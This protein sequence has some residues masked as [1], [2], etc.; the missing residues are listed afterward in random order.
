[1]E[2]ANRRRSYA[3]ASEFFFFFIVLVIRSRDALDRIPADPGYDYIYSSAKNGIES[4]SQGDPYFHLAARLISLLAAQ[5]P[6][7]LQALT[8][9]LMTHV[10]WA[11]CAVGFSRVIFL[12]TSR[13]FIGTVSGLL[14]VTA[15]HASESSL[16]NVGNVKWPLTLLLVVICSSSK[17]TT[18]H[19]RTSLFIAVSVGLSQPLAV[20]AMTGPL[21]RWV[22]NRAITKIERSLLAVLGLALVVQIF[23]VG[24]VG[25]ASGRAAKV[26]DPWEGMGIF[27]WSGLLGPMLISVVNII[28]I[29][30]YRRRTSGAELVVL[31]SVH[32]LVFGVMNYLLGGIADRYFVL[33]MTLSLV[34][35]LLGLALTL[36]IARSTRKLLMTLF[37]AGLAIPSMKWF[38]VGWYL[39]TGPTWRDEI[40]RAR[41]VCGNAV[42]VAETLLITADGKIELPCEYV[43]HD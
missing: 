30:I 37:I 40:S 7:E 41:T 43:R 17:F 21:Y 42:A 38:S 12:E 36:P 23:K 19:Q 33:P 13:R 24:L 1:M 8:Q 6:I 20:L 4:L 3:H 34:A 11:L 2:S 35:A 18:L 5:F 9:S 29:L 15:P 28:L 22:H 32:A 27:W 25:V 10:I 39:T 16:G 26:T 14:L 31:L